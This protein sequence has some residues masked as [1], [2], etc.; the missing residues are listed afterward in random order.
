MR[1]STQTL[2][3][4]GMTCTNCVKHVEEA[5]SALDG[6]Q[7][8]SVDL[9]LKRATVDFSPKLT[10]AAMIEEAVR[11]GGYEVVEPSAKKPRASGCCCG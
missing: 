11:Q 8:A 2:H 5:L 7:R 9:D 1:K 4:E 3:I 6:V 10:N